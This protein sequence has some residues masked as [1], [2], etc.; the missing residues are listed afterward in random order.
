MFVFNYT[1]NYFSVSVMRSEYFLTFICTVTRVLYILLRN[2]VI[3]LG[4]YK[5]IAK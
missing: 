4:S 2:I 3:G 5:R 1:N